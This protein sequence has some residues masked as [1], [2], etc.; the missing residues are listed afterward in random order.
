MVV[1]KENVTVAWRS[2][3]QV[4]LEVVLI[5]HF[6]EVR[7]KPTNRSRCYAH[8]LHDCPQMFRMFYAGRCW[9]QAGLRVVALH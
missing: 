2:C 4:G 3:E 9:D 5:C 6:G 7:F 8:D 1:E